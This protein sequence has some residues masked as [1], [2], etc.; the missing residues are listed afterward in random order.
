MKTRIALHLAI[1]ASAAGVF[2]A[3]A[4]AK[5]N[6]DAPVPPATAPVP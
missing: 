1:L 3:T 6:G 2:T 4:I 5:F